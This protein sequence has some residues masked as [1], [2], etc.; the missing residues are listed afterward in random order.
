MIKTV[1]SLLFCAT[2]FSA[3]AERPV[4]VRVER[5]TI[6]DALLTC[7]SEPVVPEIRTQ[8]DVALYVIDLREYGRICE[9]QLQSV[10][11]L[12]D[13]TLSK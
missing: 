1:L 2:L 5:I 12:Q 9:A 4:A 7:P 11:Q 3:C 13:Q 8:R 6:P 10:K